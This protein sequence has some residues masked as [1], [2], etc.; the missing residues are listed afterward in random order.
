MPSFWVKHHQLRIL[1]V[2][3]CT[4]THTYA[5]TCTPSC[6]FGQP[7][8]TEPFW[9]LITSSRVW[10]LAA[11]RSPLVHGHGVWPLVL[12]AFISWHVLSISVPG[13][14]IY[15]GQ[16]TAPMSRSKQPA[17]LPT[18]MTTCQQASSQWPLWAKMLPNCGKERFYLQ[19]IGQKL[20]K[21]SHLAT[22]KSGMCH[23][24]LSDACLDNLCGSD[25]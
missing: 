1:D 10:S 25:S 5:C 6:P 20:V 4:H 12:L 17:L 19:P 11:L 16:H 22:K 15:Q 9:S 18:T 21:W 23:V 7:P 13:Y 14:H 24:I 3:A 8:R 2:H